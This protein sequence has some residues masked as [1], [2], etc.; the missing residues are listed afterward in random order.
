MTDFAR[1]FKLINKGIFGV[2]LWQ[3]C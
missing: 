3:G 2:V 1:D